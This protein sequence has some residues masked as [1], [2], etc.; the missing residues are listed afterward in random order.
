MGSKFKPWKSESEGR[1]SGVAV[2]AQQRRVG[3]PMRH[4]NSRRPLESEDVRRHVQEW[5]YP[6]SDYE[7][8]EYDCE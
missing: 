5:D 8:Y 6:S 1:R 7:E 2:A 4:R 3:E